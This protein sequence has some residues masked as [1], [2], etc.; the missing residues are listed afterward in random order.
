MDDLRELLKRS[1]P[2]IA[3]AYSSS[4]AGAEELGREIERA[5]AAQPAPVEPIA[6]R[7]KLRSC[8]E[9]LA[10]AEK[11]IAELEAA[12]PAPGG[13][14]T[15]PYVERLIRIFRDHPHDDTSALVLRDYGTAATAAVKD[16]L[17]T[18]QCGRPNV[19][20]AYP[21]CGE[22]CRHRLAQPKPAEGG[23]VDSTFQASVRPWVL[24]CFGDEAANDVRERGDRLLEEVLELLQSHGY[25]PARVATL[26]DYVFSRPAGEPAQEVGGVMVT[27]AAYCLATGIDMH[28]AG[29]TELARIWT[30]V[31]AIRAKQ[32]SKRGLHTPLP[33]PPAGSGEAVAVPVGEVQR[34][35]NAPATAWL[36]EPRNLKHGT[37]LYAGAPPADAEALIEDVRD[38]I[39]LGCVLRQGGPD[40]IDLQ[41]LSDALWEAVQIADRIDGRLSG[42]EG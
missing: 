14:A 13:V 39:A 7:E 23:A 21:D 25:D 16:S 5:L 35:C 3:Y 41:E 6:L 22:Y 1:L 10:A 36:Y 11:R 9:S 24:E 20:C 17:T 30:K 2:F 33:V 12:Q 27:L 42:G 38:I 8:E 28:A 40:P 19:A 29:E 18:A 26:R 31:D 32:A 37:K 15:G 34:L 4:L